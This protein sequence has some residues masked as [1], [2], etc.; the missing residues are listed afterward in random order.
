MREHKPGV[1]WFTADEPAWLTPQNSGQPLPYAVVTPDTLRKVM[2]A[3]SGR[4]PPIQEDAKET[5]ADM[6]SSVPRGSA[7]ALG[8]LRPY[9]EFP[10][11]RLELERVWGALSDNAE[12]PSIDDYTIIIGR[13]GQKTELV[14]AS[15][16]PFRVQASLGH[17]AFDVRMESWL[18]TDTI[19]RGGFGQVIVNR[20]HA[21]TLERGISLMVMA[22]GGSPVLSEYRA[23]L[24]APVR[25]FVPGFSDSLP[26][27][28][29]R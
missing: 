13:V 19:R 20:T 10:I 8:V 25:R 2:P 11:D 17:L 6:V 3:D 21:L 12:L 5:L 4:S 15:R 23:G 26:A 16:R 14:K 24:F 1:R 22:D 9:R 18:P 7:Y 28:C 29:Y 27:P